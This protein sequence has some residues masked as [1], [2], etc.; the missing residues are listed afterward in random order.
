M[1]D[2]HTCLPCGARF[3]SLDRIKEHLRYCDAFQ[4]DLASRQYEL[5][6]E[7]QR[8]V[9]AP[10]RP[11]EAEAEK[12]PVRELAPPRP[13]LPRPATPTWPEQWMRFPDE[14][15]HVLRSSKRPSLDYYDQ[16]R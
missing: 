10:A 11:Q 12:R 13:R 8:R 1:S 16:R 7:N 2:W 15:R 3:D 9:I 5:R 6:R 14:Y 4:V